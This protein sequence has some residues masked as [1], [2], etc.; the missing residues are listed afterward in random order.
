MYVVPPVCVG[1]ATTDENGEYAF[2][3]V[4]LGSYRIREELQPGWRQT[5]PGQQI[6]QM[7]QQSNNDSW[8]LI[9]AAVGHKGLINYAATMGI[10]YD[11]TVNAL[12]P[13]EMAKPAM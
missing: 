1:P 13:A 10:P 11:R 3:G 6:R 5:R 4:P 12:T 2:V 7:V 9:L 8:A